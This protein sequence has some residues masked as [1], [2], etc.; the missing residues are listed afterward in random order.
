MSISTTSIE[1]LSINAIRTLSMDAVQQANSGHPGTPMALAPVVYTLWNKH[2]KYDPANPHWHSRDRFVLSCGHAS[3]LLY[4]T[5]HVAGVKKADGASEPSITI[6]NIRNFRQLHSPCAGHPEVHEAAGI[7]TTTGP[8]GQGVATSVGMAIAGQWQAARFDK[9]GYDLFG[10]NVY[11]LCSDGDLMEGISTEAASTAGHLKL[12]NLCWIYDD[13]NITIEGDTELAFTEDMPGKFRALGWHVIEVA[14]ANDLDALD[15]AFT[16]FKKTDDKPT[17]IVVK[18][19]I[20][21]GAPTKANTHGAHGAPLGEEEIAGTKKAYGWTYGKFEV[22]AEVYED[23]N[24]NLGARGA[25]AKAKWDADFAKYSKENAEAAATWSSIMSGELPEGWDADI[26][27]FPADAKGVATRASGGKVLNAIAAK[28]PGML[29]GSADLEP[30]TKTGLTFEGA[31]D[32]EP[33]TYGGRNFH[34]GIREHAMAAIGNGMA[35]CGLRP[36]VSTFFVFSDYLR[37]ALRLSAIMKA[38]V[39][40]IF[41]HDSI[42]VGEDGPTH[43]PV[44]HLAAIRA[45]P[46][47]AVFRP[48]DSNEV[49]A[50]YKTAVEL[51]D[52]PSVMVLTRQNLP[53][54]DREKYACPGKS[55]KGA[56]VIADCEGTPEVLLMGTGS[57]LSLVIEAYEKLTAEGVKARAI[58][59]PC[60]ELFYEQ[61]AAYQK[62]VMPCEVKARV[63]VEA[64]IQQ[65]WD[66]LLGFQGEFVGMNSFGASAP[67][68]ELFPY[69]GITADHVVA[70]AKKSIGG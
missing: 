51:A 65:A 3:M 40:Y 21:W 1:Q 41:T 31:G 7:E 37:P 15:A 17:L 57:E 69:F 64:G 24:A 33:G 55:A 5:L 53:T 56:Y 26:P 22:P 47:V 48:G 39:L 52:R 70:A 14:D 4:S 59:V 58:S 44:E 34:F 12:S 63:A 9:P 30:S 16:E 50:C 2:L 25:E 42:G 20:A 13:N 27:S 29:G 28:L 61:D 32:F 49:G 18:S 68:E 19:I 38:P 45:I 60:L 36:Y 35:L 6:D 23:F 8:L 10:Y 67:A 54:L 43:Q 62:E 46:N 66:R 11:A